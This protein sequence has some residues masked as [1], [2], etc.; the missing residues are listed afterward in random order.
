ML[1]SLGKRRCSS[2]DR[3]I[4]QLAQVQPRHQRTLR[5]SPAAFAGTE[6]TLLKNASYSAIPG[7]L[8]TELGLVA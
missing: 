7:H 4:L 5:S 1:E 8:R 2:R 6:K 3:Y